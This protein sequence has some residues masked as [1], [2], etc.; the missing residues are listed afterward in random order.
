MASYMAP[1]PMKVPGTHAHSP[2]EAARMAAA[3][4]KRVLGALAQG[5]VIA[6]GHNQKFCFVKAE[7]GG[8]DYFLHKK[9]ARD[10]KYV[11]LP[12]PG[13]LV[14]F[15][16]VCT[17][18]MQWQA[19]EPRWDPSAPIAP[20]PLVQMVMVP[21][22]PQMPQQMIPQMMMQPMPPMMAQ[23]LLMR[24]LVPQRPPPPGY[25]AYGDGRLPFSG[26]R[27]YESRPPLP[28]GEPPMDRHLRRPPAQSDH[29]HFYDDPRNAPYDSRGHPYDPRGQPYDPRGQ[30]YDPRGQPYDPRGPPM[31]PRS[32]PTDLR[33]PDPR[34]LPM[35]PRGLFMDPRGPPMDPRSPPPDAFYHRG[36][37]QPRALP[38]GYRADVAGP[39][40]YSAPGDDGT[41]RSSS[42]SRS[43]D[44]RGD[45][46][47]ARARQHFDDAAPQGLPTDPRRRK[48]W[49]ADG[50]YDAEA[51]AEN[52]EADDAPAARA[53]QPTD[54][55]AAALA[56]MRRIEQGLGPVEHDV[57]ADDVRPRV[58]RG[59]ARS[60]AQ[61]DGRTRRRDESPP[62]DERRKRRH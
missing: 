33:G 37:L 35:D 11:G 31:D 55:L 7:D 43:P 41:L 13:A 36:L 57:V 18:Q 44:A 30:P 4:S 2:A 27:L 38:P 23:Q 1:P 61:D 17:K 3:D 14:Q 8:S 16:V 29:M 59:L 15:R 22:Q 34:G 60:A 49:H 53:A 26:D 56:A 54:P 50:A 21:Q 62:D 47:D 25:R 51:A 24:D 48:D 10:G 40:S 58:P 45:F 32:L 19:D 39:P 20:Q 12:P 28:P 46:G 6:P 9:I 5:S 52:F 42:R